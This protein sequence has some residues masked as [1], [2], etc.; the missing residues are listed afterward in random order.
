VVS[1]YDIVLVW[2]WS[3][4]TI[5]GT[6]LLAIW[7]LIYLASDRDT[8]SL[9]CTGNARPVSCAVGLPMAIVTL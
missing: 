4:V 8:H 2:C 7:S 3:T 5:S 9:L 6:M 1:R